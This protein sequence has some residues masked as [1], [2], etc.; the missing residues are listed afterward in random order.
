MNRYIRKELLWLAAAALAVA[1]CAPKP[2]VQ[3]APESNQQPTILDTQPSLQ[4]PTGTTPAATE[5]VGRAPAVEP[6]AR[7]GL[8]ATDPGTVQLAS[9]E[10]QLVEFFAFW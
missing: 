4:M 1:A 7:P 8:H 10:L 9:G 2:A 6:T 3:P 5:P